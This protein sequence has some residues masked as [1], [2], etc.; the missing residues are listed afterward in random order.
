MKHAGRGLMLRRAGGE[1]DGDRGGQ[2]GVGKIIFAER[3]RI[4]P[5]LEST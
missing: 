1:R 2:K 3:R 4:R 5:W